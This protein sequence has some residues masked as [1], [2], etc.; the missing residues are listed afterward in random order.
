MHDCAPSVFLRS[1]ALVTLYLC[2]RFHIFDIVLLEEY[3]FR[4]KGAHTLRQSCLHIAWD[5]LP[6]VAREMHLSFDSL[7]VTSTLGLL[8]SLMDIHHDKSLRSLLKD[9]SISLTFKTHI[10]FCLNKG[11]GLWLVAKPF[12]CSFH[13]AHSIF[14]SVL[15]FCFGLIQLST[16][17][18]FTCECEHGLDASDTHLIC[19]LFGG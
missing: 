19:C 8:T 10:C 17:S 2:S 3:V 5:G 13:I 7:V 11:V 12:I 18:L 1:Q 4:L 16:C 15:H 14:T 9:D 6:L